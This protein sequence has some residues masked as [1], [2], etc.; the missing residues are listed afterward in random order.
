MVGML[1]GYAW[2]FG[3]G[4]LMRDVF[5][6]WANEV[7][8]RT[9]LRSDMVTWLHSPLAAKLMSDVVGYTDKD[10]ASIRTILFP[11]AACSPSLL[12]SRLNGTYTTDGLRPRRPSGIWVLG[13][14]L[15]ATT[16]AVPQLCMAVAH[17]E[18]TTSRESY[19]SA[20]VLIHWSKF[21]C[22]CP[23]DSARWRTLRFRATPFGHE[24]KGLEARFL[25]STEKYP[26]LQ[27]WIT[28]SGRQDV[29]FFGRQG[30][31]AWNLHEHLLNPINAAGSGTFEGARAFLLATWEREPV[32]WIYSMQGGFYLS[33]E[34]ICAPNRLSLDRYLFFLRVDESGIH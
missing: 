10:I 17:L 8:D 12:T 4:K 32:I 14:T 20:T 28:F 29:M 25:G 7:M 24:A 33:E 15:P 5:A 13:G 22:S 31:Q 26:M 34:C 21:E 1:R 11:T 2:L 3:Q 27:P 18:N 23:K 9:E 16:M 6:R 19:L 30:V